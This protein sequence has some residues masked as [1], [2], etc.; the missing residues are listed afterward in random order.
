MFSFSF[1]SPDEIIFY[2]EE[3]TAQI[4]TIKGTRHLKPFERDVDFWESSIGQISEISDGLFNV[5]RQWL[6]MEGIFTSDDVQRQL[7]AEATEFK[8]I[9]TIWQDEIIGQIR[10]QP[11][12]LIVATK[13]SKTKENNDE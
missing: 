13:M 1:R 5:Q 11:N 7:A 9:N 6:Y 8:T 10:Q 2:V 3:Q 4:S 12:A